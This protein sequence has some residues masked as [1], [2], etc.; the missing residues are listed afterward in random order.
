MQ[1]LD[2]SAQTFQKAEL[3]A[4]RSFPFIEVLPEES[5]HSNVM[6]SP[7]LLMQVTCQVGDGRR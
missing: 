3:L 4:H 5:E 2:L 6:A 7:L 1:A